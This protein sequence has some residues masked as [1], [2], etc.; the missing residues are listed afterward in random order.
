MQY[1]VPRTRRRPRRAPDVRPAPATTP[2]PTSSPDHRGAPCLPRPRRTPVPLQPTRRAPTHEP[3]QET[4]D[5]RA[6]IAGPGGPQPPRLP[7]RLPRAGPDRHRAGGGAGE[8]LTAGADRPG[9]GGRDAPGEDG[10]P[11]RHRRLGLDA[12]RRQARRA[13]LPRQHGAVA[14]R[15]LRLRLPRRHRPHRRPGRGPAREG[16]DQRAD[17][18]LR[19]GGRHHHHAVQPR[20][21]GA[22]R[23]LRRPHPALARVR[24]R[25]PAVR[26]GAR[27]LPRRPGRPRLL[28]LLPPPRRRHLHVPL[29]LRGRGA[30]ADGH[31]RHGLRP[32]DAE[33]A[34][35]RQRPGGLEVRL[36]RRGRQHPLRPRVRLHDRPSCGRPPTTATPT[37]RS[38]TGPTTT[39]ASRC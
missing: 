7:L 19:R 26:R 20:P 37:S 14:V 22:A 8:R 38:A 9:A 33:Q 34:A 35:G 32:A 4:R 6:D 2:A 24:E 15:H 25:D 30:R 17:A 36:Q 18:G 13:V 11:G 16:P 31:D 21:A 28:L 1:T 10:A 27:A 12:V 39:R 23:P 5:E 29:P 3:H